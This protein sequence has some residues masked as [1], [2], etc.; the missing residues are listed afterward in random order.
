MSEAKKI[1]IVEDD[2]GFCSIL[3]TKFE[4]TEFATIIAED[5]ETGLEKA[6]KEHPD[7][8]LLDIMLPGIDGI[9]VA[10]KMR[11]AGVRV[12]IVYLTNVS[13]TE[14]ISE[15]MLVTGGETDYIVKTD[16]RIEDI[17]ER[18]RKRLSLK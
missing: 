14:R 17:I 1:L 10:K 9:E 15:A 12:P 13:D 7:L 8:V 4:G 5:G 11:Q 2:E 6:R 18:I 16:V 3:E